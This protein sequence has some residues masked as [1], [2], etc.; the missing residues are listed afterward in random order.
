MVK[1]GRAGAVGAVA[2]ETRR[3]IANLGASLS[4]SNLSKPDGV[5]KYIRSPDCFFFEALLGR[6]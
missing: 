1:Y 5:I 2:T 3:G 6:A 4:F